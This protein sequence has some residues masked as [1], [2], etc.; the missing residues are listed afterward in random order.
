MP[1]AKKQH[2]KKRP[3]GRYACRY[4]DQWF[5]GITEEETLQAREEY[6]KAE[7]QQA[8]LRRNGQ[9]VGEYASEWLP[10]HK[11]GV[12]DSTYNSYAS[13][14]QHALPLISSLPLKQVSSDDIASTFAA[15]AGQSASYIHKA[16]I[17]LTAIFDSAVDAGFILKNPCRATSVKPPKGTRGTHRA[18][19]AEEVKLIQETPHRM[20]AAALVMLYCGL[21]RGEALALTADCIHDGYI[22]VERSVYFVSNQP[23]ISTPKSEAGSRRVPVPDLLLPFLRGYDGYITGGDKPLTETAF[24]RGWEN[25]MK[26]LSAAAGHPVSFR[27]HDLRHTF[28]T[29]CRDAGVDIHQTQIWM[30]HSDIHLIVSVYDH[31][32][33]GREADAFSQFQAL[34][35]SQNGSQNANAPHLTLVS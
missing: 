14:L 8:L 11:A 35:R 4:K 5:Y 2:L 31:P 12:K 23:L 22:H 25:Y 13:V 20:Q 6:K 1:R 29:M 30:G 26:T 28:C 21:R 33:A 19:T 34:I 3:D 16:R 15:L 24:S 18:L 7:A 27:A 32:G 9:T 17:L 10:V